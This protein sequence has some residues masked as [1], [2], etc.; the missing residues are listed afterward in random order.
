MGLFLT[1]CEK[2]FKMDQCLSIKLDIKLLEENTG[3]KLHDVNITN[4]F[5]FGLDTQSKGN[6][7]KNK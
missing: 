3:N 5:F 4:D 7:S 2:L 6:K 1:P